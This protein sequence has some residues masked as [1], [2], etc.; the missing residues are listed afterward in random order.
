MIRAPRAKPKDTSVDLRSCVLIRNAYRQLLAP[1]LAAPSE[2]LATPLRF[3]TCTKSVRL[4]PSRVTGTVGGLSHGYSR[5]G[6]NKAEVQTGKVS[7]RREIGQA[8][9]ST[10]G[11][12][13][14]M[15]HNRVSN[16]DVLRLLFPYGSNSFAPPPLPSY[17]HPAHDALGARNLD[18][19]FGSRPP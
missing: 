2:R 15:L 17:P 11:T 4:E 13:Q 5:Y 3:H 14:G 7:L 6:L 10:W 9:S 18:A 12:V 1:L 8:T 19:P 16:T